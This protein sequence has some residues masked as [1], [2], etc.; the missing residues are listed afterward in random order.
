MLS[1]WWP[2]PTK[3]P[4]PRLFFLID[5]TFDT[6]PRLIQFLALIALYLGD[7]SL[8]P[9]GVQK[10]GGFPVDAGPQLA[11]RVLRRV[12]PEPC[13]ADRSLH[14]PRQYFH[15]HRGGNLRY[16]NHGPNS[17]AS[18]MARR[19][20]RHGAAPRRRSRPDP[21][22]RRARRSWARAPGLRAMASRRR[23]RCRRR[24]RTTARSAPRRRRATRR[25]RTSRRRCQA[26]E[27][28]DPRDRC[29]GFGRTRRACM[30]AIPERRGK[31]SGRPSKASTSR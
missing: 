2:D 7:L 24:S 8:H 23:R 4:Q 18:R 21:I 13:R 14:L 30:A 11:V 22:G 16:R 1:G 25:C 31:F 27:D 6:P 5:K 19:R 9:P 17:M 3:L 28:Q 20:E 29:L 26:Q 12:Y 10:A 15:R